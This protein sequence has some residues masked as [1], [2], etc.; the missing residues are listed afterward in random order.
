[1]LNLWISIDK[2]LNSKDKCQNRM[3]VYLIDFLYFLR[4]RIIIIHISKSYFDRR[5]KAKTIEI[6]N[7]SSHDFN[8]V[9]NFKS[10]FCYAYV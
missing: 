1:M 8:F 2:Y 5:H 9:S 4:T 10:F 6:K 3:G 7:I